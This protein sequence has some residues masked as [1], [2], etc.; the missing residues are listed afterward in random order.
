M[1]DFKELD[2]DC[3]F[4][5]DISAEGMEFL[6]FDSDGVVCKS[7][8]FDEWIEQNELFH[9][10]SIMQLALRTGRAK[11]SKDGKT[12]TLVVTVPVIKKKR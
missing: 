5:V 11:V 2:I 12:A 1:S 4:D 8:Y 9:E 6:E 10:Y 3:D 7:E